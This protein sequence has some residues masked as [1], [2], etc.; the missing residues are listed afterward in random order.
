[1]SAT[2]LRPASHPASHPASAATLIGGGPLGLLS[3]AR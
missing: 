2:S 3:G 1:M